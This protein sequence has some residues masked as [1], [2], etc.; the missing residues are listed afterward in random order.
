VTEKTRSTLVTCHR[1]CRAI[2]RP[3]VVVERIE[4]QGFPGDPAISVKPFQLPAENKLVEKTEKVPLL[5]EVRAEYEKQTCASFTDSLTGLYNHGFLLELLDRELKRFRRYSAPFS[6]ALINVDGLGR[7]NRKRGSIQGD[8]VLRE[9][10]DIIQECLRESD[11]AARYDG[12]IFAIILLYTEAADAEPVFRR[13]GDIV[14]SRFHG[15]LTVSVGCVSSEK[16]GDTEELLRRAKEALAKAKAKAGATTFVDDS[17]RPAPDSRPSV[18][19]ADDDA[20]SAR[21]LKAMLVPLNCDTIIVENGEE[22]LQAFEVNEIDLVLLDAVM[23]RM[24]GFETCRR[25]KSDP[26]TRMV[27]VIMVTGLGDAESRVRAIEAGADEFITKPPDRMELTAR[28]RALLQAKRL[29]DNLVSIENVLISLANAVEAKDSYTEGHVKRVS[30]LAVNL[31]RAM[32]LPE[33]DIEALRIGGILHDI[34]K[35]GISDFVLNKAGPL[36]P[37]ESEIVRSHPVIGWRMAEPLATTLKGALEVIRHHHEKLD[38]SGYPD[39]L[40]G[41]DISMVARIMAIADIYDALVT[42]RPY[43]RGMS[44]DEAMATIRQEAEEGLLDIEIVVHLVALV[45]KEKERATPSG[46][47]PM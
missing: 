44:R 36:N 34:G 18:L 11:L 47:H 6:L 41:E 21:L 3:C 35:I 37:E 39:G 42:D 31:G 7:Y 23:P 22:A 19:V 13:L 38:G 1:S 32:R 14:E 43:R 45:E 8:L 9:L 27:P 12:S 25:L 28:V 20:T 29:N 33:A 2:P 16:A 24:D 46:V 4:D 30:S 17:R 5:T 10:A 40:K 15:E 26:D